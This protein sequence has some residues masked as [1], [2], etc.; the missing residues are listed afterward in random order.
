VLNVAYSLGMM[1]GPLVGGVLI[2]TWGFSSAL[3]ATGVCFA[4]YLFATRGLS[5]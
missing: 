4:C 3:G 1:L 2:D 5:A